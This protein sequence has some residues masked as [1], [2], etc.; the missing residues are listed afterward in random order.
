MEAAYQGS[1]STKNYTNYLTSSSARQPFPN[2]SPVLKS[3][4]NN[5]SP[6]PEQQKIND[7]I[8]KEVITGKYLL[9]INEKY[10]A[11]DDNHTFTIQNP[12]IQK[13]SIIILSI[14]LED[15]D[16][17]FPEYVVHNIQDGSFDITVK[18]INIDKRIIVHYSVY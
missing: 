16:I 18:S 9:D 6:L 1:Y 10:D 2:I 13:S 7:P 15:D 17:Y 11:D 4:P 5:A 14:V 12:G 3:V 8:V